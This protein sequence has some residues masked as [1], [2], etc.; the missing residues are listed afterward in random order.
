[1]E[2][3]EKRKYGKKNSNLNNKI[4]GE[5]IEKKSDYYN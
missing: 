2:V 3:E 4:I 1:M 5:N